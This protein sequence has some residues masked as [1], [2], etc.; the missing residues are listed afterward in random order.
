DIDPEIH[1][2]I[3]ECFA[4]VDA[5]RDRGIDARVLVESVDRDEIETG[6]RD[7]VEVRVE[8]ITH[9]AIPED[10]P[11]PTQEGAVQVTYEILGDLVQRNFPHESWML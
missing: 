10:V 11:K 7:P 5:L 6:V 3:D 8:R 4:Y 2:E 9:P 1:A